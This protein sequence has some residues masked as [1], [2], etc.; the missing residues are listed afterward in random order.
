MPSG[1]S[2]AIRIVIVDDHAIVREGLMAI[3]ASQPDMQVV[4]MASTARAGL[5]AV[6]EHQPNVVLLDLRLPQFDG[7]SAVS[8]FKERFPKLRVLMLSSADGDK[9]IEACLAA[10]AKGYVLKSSPA[11]V[12]LAAI[13]A[14]CAGETFLS[15]EIADE[16][17]G[18]LG[19]ADLTPREI[20]ILE[21]VSEGQSNADIAGALG[22]AE[23]TVKNHLSS[24]FAKLGASDRTHAVTIGLQRGIIDLPRRRST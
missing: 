17:A 7:L 1:G 8:V 22:V 6:A 14:V 18:H 9:A 12:L 4:A 19:S 23:K 10:G 20:E 11:D 13:R 3:F 24:V 15:P 5:E 16:L 2:E 21:A